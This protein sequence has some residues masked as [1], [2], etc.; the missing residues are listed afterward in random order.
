MI[1]LRFILTPTIILAAAGCGTTQMRSGTEQLLLSDAVDRSIDRLD[2]SA[3]DGESVFLDSTYIEPDKSPRSGGVDNYVNSNYIVSALRQKLITSGCLLKPSATEADYVVEARV[4]ALGTDALEVTYGIPASNA[5]SAA[6]SL[7]TAVPAAPT[8][9]EISVGKRN[10][11]MSTSK[12]VLFAYHR[13]TGQPVW[14]S[15]AAVAR[16]DAKD[17]WLFG[18]GPLQRGSIYN[19]TQFAG[20]RLRFPWNSREK[21]RESTGLKIADS[22]QFVV[23]R[24]LEQRLAD[25]SAEAGAATG[26]QDSSTVVPASH[27]APVDQ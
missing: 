6:A 16:S 27:E 21:T 14:Q 7:L 25:R 2:L 19:G 10:A 24:V 18:A 1:S 17:S 3:L 23:P 5:L 12:V 9:P 4:G 15:G 26:E 22:H 13:Q 8:I 20:M 11:A